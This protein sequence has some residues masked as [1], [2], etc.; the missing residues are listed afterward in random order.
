MSDASG[1]ASGGTSIPTIVASGSTDTS[2]VVSGSNP[3]VFSID[4]PGMI[5]ECSPTRISWDP[6][7]VQ[8]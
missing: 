5:T 1:F 3:F 7:S 6:S 8:G 4:P 2:C